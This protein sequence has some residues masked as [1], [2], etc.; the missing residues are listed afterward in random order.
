[1]K[2]EEISKKHTY[3]K[4]KK[5]SKEILKVIRDSELITNKH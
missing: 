4:R 5:K 2:K 3:T 1:M